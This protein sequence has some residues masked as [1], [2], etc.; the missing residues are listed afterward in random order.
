MYRCVLPLL[1]FLGILA[2]QEGEPKQTAPSKPILPGAQPDGSVKLPN[3]WSL[4]PAGKQLELGDFP[5]NLALHPSGRWLAALHAGYGTHEVVIVDLDPKRHKIVSRVA[6]DQTFA[7]VCFTPDGKH[8]YASGGEFD[9]LH[10]FQFE[11][12]Y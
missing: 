7:G 9:L 2:T 3:L 4:R 6:L 10:A 11:D 12:G 5:V 8:L 1:I